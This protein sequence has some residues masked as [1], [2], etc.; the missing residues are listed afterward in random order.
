VFLDVFLSFE[1]SI[2]FL[3][4]NECHPSIAFLEFVVSRLKLSQLAGTVR[5]PRTANKHEC[6]RSAAVIG[7]S[8]G[9][10]IRRRELKVRSCVAGLKSV[11]VALEH[12]QL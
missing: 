6:E 7:E 12:G 10:A 1:E 3:G 11:G 8:H 2:D 4:R 5:S 9:F